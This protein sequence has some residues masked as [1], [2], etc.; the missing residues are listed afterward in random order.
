MAFD[1]A[2]ALLIG[3]GSYAH[4]PRFNVPVTAADAIAVAGVL[5]DPRYCGYPPEQ[6]TLLSGAAATREGVLAALDALAARVGE[7]DTV[8]VFYAGHGEYGDDGYY[9]TTHDTRL[10]GRKVAAGTG[11]RLSLIHI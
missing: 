3:I 11:L 4:A 1:T 5:R 8:L 9:L 2:H 10:E 7:G 6:V